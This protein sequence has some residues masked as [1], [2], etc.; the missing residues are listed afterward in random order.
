MQFL[1]QQ[2]LNRLDKIIELLQPDGVPSSGRVKTYN[3]V[4]VIEV[5]G[6]LKVAD[7]ANTTFLNKGTSIVTILGGIQLAQ[8]QGIAF[9]VN[10]NEQDVTK[11]TYTFDNSGT[12]LLYVIQRLYSEPQQ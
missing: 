12:N 1:D 10:T 11:Y 5:P 6:Q 4:T 7:T 3:L 8:N 9:P 2:A